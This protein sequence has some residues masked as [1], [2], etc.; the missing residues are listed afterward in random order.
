MSI[1]TYPLSTAS[2]TLHFDH[3]HC[4]A[5]Y[6][7]SS[8]NNIAPPHYF[9]FGK[10]LEWPNEICPPVASQSCS[11]EY[12]L[13]NN[14]VYLTRLKGSEVSYCIPRVDYQSGQIY[15]MYDCIDPDNLSYS[16]ANNIFDSTMFVLNSENNIYKCIF[17]NNNSVSFSE[18]R[19]TDIGYIKT[20]D[21]YIWK[22]MATVDEADRL[23]FLTNEWLPIRSAF[24]ASVLYNGIIPKVENGGTGYVPNNAI[25]TVTG[26]GVG[27]HLRPLIQNGIINGIEV[28][29][30]GTGYTYAELN[31]VCPDLTQR[32]GIGAVLSVDF[33]VVNF[34]SLQSTAQLTAVSGDI[35]AVIVTNGGSNY[36]IGEAIAVIS[37]DGEGATA[38]VN[39]DQNGTV[40]GVELI[41]R[42]YGYSWAEID[43]IGVGEGATARVI[44]SPNGGHGHDIVEETRS[45]VVCARKSIERTE[46]HDIKEWVDFRQCGII[47]NPDA[48]P[49]SNTQYKSWFQND[50]GTTC[51]SIYSEDIAED[52]F[53]LDEMLVR[54]SDESYWFVVAVKDNEIVLQSPL[55]EVPQ[56]GDE[57]ANVTIT[58]DALTGE[59][60][61]TPNTAL[62]T[63]GTGGF[64]VESIKTPEVDKFSGSLLYYDNREV[65]HQIEDSAVIIQT[66]IEF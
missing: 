55:N 3:H 51:Y 21:Q 65:Y 22:Y 45:R 48:V 12:Q 62:F 41:E 49:E 1:T 40:V 33:P 32:R 34:A 29:N 10:T 52:A 25:I 43:I 66:F 8:V 47:I 39:V 60:I 63:A 18:P 19:G 16:G 27:A 17:N 28:I 61:I 36:T 13:R 4:L 37:G 58:T 59:T 53:Q 64:V 7:V 14:M 57:F 44:V 11:E 42:G 31:V 54:L 23:L 50:T 24:P 26:D 38:S 9:F 6:F 30:P 56:A 46:F 5:K 2:T 20:S 15:D 35:S